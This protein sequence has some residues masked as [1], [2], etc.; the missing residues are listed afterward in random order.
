[1]YT[2]KKMHFSIK[3]NINKIFFQLKFLIL[4]LILYFNTN[5][6]NNLIIT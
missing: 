1:M 2:M 6:I 3:Y 5:N 4:I